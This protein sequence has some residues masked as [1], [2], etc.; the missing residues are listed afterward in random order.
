MRN[1]RMLLGD[2]RLWLYLYLS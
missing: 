2:K 1:T